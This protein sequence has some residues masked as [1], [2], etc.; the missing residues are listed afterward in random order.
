MTKNF[1]QRGKDGRTDGRT[2]VNQYTPTFSKRGYNKAGG[3]TDKKKHESG[4]TEYRRHNKEGGMTDKKNHNKE[5]GMTENM[6][7][8]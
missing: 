4:M 5:S 2:D 3:M 1:H 8:L 6:I 7:S